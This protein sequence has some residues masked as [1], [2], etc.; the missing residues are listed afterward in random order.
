MEIETASAKMAQ[1]RVTPRELEGIQQQQQGQGLGQGQSM[2]WTDRPDRVAMPKPPTKPS[3]RHADREAMSSA[4][5]LSTVIVAPPPPIFVLPTEL[6]LM[7]FRHLNHVPEL[8]R[9][10]AVCKRLRQVAL[11]RRLWSQVE[12]H[13]DAVSPQGILQ[14]SALD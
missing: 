3:A 5:Q 11:H 8:I 7:I 4:G 10:S 1:L 13:D 14:Q 9:L 12:F 6:M 2:A